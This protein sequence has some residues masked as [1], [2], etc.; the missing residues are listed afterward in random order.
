MSQKFMLAGILAFS[1]TSVSAVRADEQKS[2]TNE[3]RKTTIDAQTG[4]VQQQKS[5]QHSAEGQHTSPNGG[6]ESYHASANSATT[7]NPDGSISE[8]EQRDKASAK[9]KAEPNGDVSVE[10]KKEHSEADAVIK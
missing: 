8:S 1:L 2:E 6:N 7:K 5:T 4:E 10:Q 3:Q 9:V